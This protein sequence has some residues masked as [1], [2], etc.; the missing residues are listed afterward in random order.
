[1]RYSSLLR[2][3]ILAASLMVQAASIGTA[4]GA[5]QAQATMSGLPQPPVAAANN[6]HPC[7]QPNTPSIRPMRWGYYPGYG[8]G[9]VPPART[10]YP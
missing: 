8:C 5:Q 9:P 2:A 1:M 4:L 6:A 7:P 3:T 10:V